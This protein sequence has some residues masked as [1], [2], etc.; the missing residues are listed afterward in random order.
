MTR[1]LSD[2][3]LSKRMSRPFSHL[4]KAQAYPIACVNI[5]ALSGRFESTL[6]KGSA[7]LLNWTVNW[8]LIMRLQL[9]RGCTSRLAKMMKITTRAPII[10]LQQHRPQMVHWLEKLY[11]MSLHAFMVPTCISWLLEWPLKWRLTLRQRI[12]QRRRRTWHIATP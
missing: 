11:C 2:E 8:T 9:S 12:S 7:T 1:V 6:S 3:D 5:S 4:R 10:I